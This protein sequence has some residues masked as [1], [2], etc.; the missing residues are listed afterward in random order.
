[1]ALGFGV[2]CSE[3]DDGFEAFALVGDEF[4]A[5]AKTFEVVVREEGGE[6]DSGEF[7]VFEFCGEVGRV[8]G[9]V[10]GLGE[11]A[12]SVG[13]AVGVCPEVTTSPSWVGLLWEIG[14]FV[15]EVCRSVAYDDVS[16]SILRIVG[17]VI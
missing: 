6:L 13:S 7:G 17:R 11:S 14:R 8:G 2:F 15:D 16:S 5:A 12:S 10:F 3:P 9:V 1:M 4:E